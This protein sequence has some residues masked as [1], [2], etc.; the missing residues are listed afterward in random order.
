MS[1]RDK[2]SVQRNNYFAHTDKNPQK[3]LGSVQ[4]SFDEVQ[5]LIEL[6]E[7]I[8]FELKVNCLNIHTDFEI[9]GMD[10]AGNILKAFAALKEKRESI[11]KQEWDEFNKE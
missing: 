11:M 8:I 10:H 9:T 5:E 2:I 6:T 3:D 1:I 4:L 7:S